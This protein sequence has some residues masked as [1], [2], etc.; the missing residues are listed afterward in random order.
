MKNYIII[1]VLLLMSFSAGTL[2][3]VVSQPK[4]PTSIVV[5]SELRNKSVQRFI[6]EWHKKGYTTKLVSASG[7]NSSFGYYIVIMEKY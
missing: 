4:Q 2:T 5:S 6:I 3:N 7:L 1:I